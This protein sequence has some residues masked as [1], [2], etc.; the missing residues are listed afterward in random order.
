MVIACPLHEVR[1]ITCAS[2]PVELIRYW[3]IDPEKLDKRA[4]SKLSNGDAESST[5]ARQ[6]GHESRID[7]EE[8]EEG[9]SMLSYSEADALPRTRSSSPWPRTTHKSASPGRRHDEMNLHSIPV[10][11]S[12]PISD[13]VFGAE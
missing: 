9:K 12:A 5:L 13:G 11:L 6:F 4:R 10:K 8:L 1:P 7:A 3:G 2:L